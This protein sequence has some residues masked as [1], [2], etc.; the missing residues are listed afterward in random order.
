M[1]ILFYYAIGALTVGITSLILIYNPA[2]YLVDKVIIQEGYDLPT[3]SFLDK[4]LYTPLTWLLVSLLV[5]I[6]IVTVVLSGGSNNL[7]LRL[8]TRKL[9]DLFNE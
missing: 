8:A 1:Q 4:V 9:E 2:M 3:R 5:W 7:R 6:P